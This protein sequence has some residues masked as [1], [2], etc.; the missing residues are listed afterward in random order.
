MGTSNPPDLFRKFVEEAQRAAAAAEEELHRLGCRHSV[1]GLFAASVAVMGR[2]RGEVSEATHGDMPSKVEK[3]AYHLWRCPSGT[4]PLTIEAIRTAIRSTDQIAHGA[5]WRFQLTAD[6]GQS[7][8]PHILSHLQ[9]DVEGVRGSAYPEQIS[10]HIVAVAGKHDSWFRSRLQTS[11][12]DLV[13][14]TW[15]IALATSAQA[16]KWL[17]T[18]PGRDIRAY[19]RGAGEASGLTAALQRAEEVLPVSFAGLAALSADT[20]TS[21]TWDALIELIGLRVEDARAATSWLCA[22]ARPL[23][24][25]PDHRVLLIS[26]PHALDRLA[27]SLEQVAKTDQAFFS[28]FQETKAKWLEKEVYESLARVFGEDAT[29]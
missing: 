6:T 29:Y 1:P 17:K 19:K 7:R 10:S 25:L 15:S 21:E 2:I 28:R 14:A 12:R 13:D 16:N 11:V 20:L 24:V 4:E 26:L 18:I 9:V 27:E 22:R 3:L 5:M 23:S 8:A